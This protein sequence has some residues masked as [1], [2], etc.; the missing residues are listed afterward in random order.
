MLEQVLFQ[1]SS[2]GA[3][4]TSP[5]Q[6]KYVVIKPELACF[7]N[8]QWHSRLP[9]IH[10]SNVLRNTHYLC[11]GGLFENKFISAAIWSSPI[12]RF[13][14]SRQVLELRRLAISDMCPK[15]SATHML[16]F[17]QRYIKK[18]MKQISLLIS[19]QDKEVHLGTIYKAANWT[20]V[21]Q[22]KFVDWAISRKRQA[23]QTKSDKIKWELRLQPDKKL[24]KKIKFEQLRIAP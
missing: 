24:P 16:G 14:D 22:T 6:I 8:S 9:N 10:S 18:N 5:H 13:L 19:Y 21:G 3:N 11:F 23:P 12:S 20:P 1:E 7:L 2:G 17:M 4:P 15:N